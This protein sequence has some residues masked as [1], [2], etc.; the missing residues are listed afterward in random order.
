MLKLKTIIVIIGFSMI[1]FSCQEQPLQP[2]VDQNYSLETINKELVSDI[3]SDSLH[4][5]MTLEEKQFEE[6]LGCMKLE[7]WQIERIKGS[8]LEEDM[9]LKNIQE[10]I[11]SLMKYEEDKLNNKLKEFE[12]IEKD[13]STIKEISEL[14]IQYDEKINYLKR[15][16]RDRLNEHKSSWILGMEFWFQDNHEQL[17]IWNTWRATGK[18]PC[19]NDK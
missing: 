8:K 14:K 15:N 3:V 17:I 4:E 6:L 18:V 13:S 1:L 2:L 11:L 7:P 16:L 19:L 10:D 12:N 5:S 9:L